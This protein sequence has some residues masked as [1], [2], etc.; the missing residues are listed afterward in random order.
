M[1]YRFS[2]RDFPIR[3]HAARTSACHELGQAEA[4]YSAPL[5]RAGRIR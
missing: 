4:G 2:V 3:H 5:G 1:K